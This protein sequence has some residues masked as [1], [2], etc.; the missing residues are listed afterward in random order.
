VLARASARGCRL[1]DVPTLGREA[2]PARDVRAVLDLVRVMRRERPRLVHTHTSKAG[3]V[4]RLAAK[5]ARV[6]VVIHQ[7][8]GH[9]FYGYYGRARTTLFVTLERLAARWTD[10]LVALTPREI[11]EHV[12]RGIGRAATWTVVQSGYP[13][14]RLPSA[15]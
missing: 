10:T 9:I 4:G 7:P 12:E 2:S 11:E 13:T 14:A 15:A 1:I 8:H 3:F 5:L 6:P